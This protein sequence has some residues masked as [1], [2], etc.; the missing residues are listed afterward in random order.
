VRAPGGELGVRVSDS[1]EVT[2]ERSVDEVAQRRLS[3]AFL[4]TLR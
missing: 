3:G 2:L 4:L 1:Y